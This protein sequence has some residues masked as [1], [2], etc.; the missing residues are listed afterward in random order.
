M[1]DW[2]GVYLDKCMQFASIKKLL[3]E[4]VF[5]CDY[6]FLPIVGDMMGQMKLRPTKVSYAIFIEE[7]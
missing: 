7:G 2:K 6:S 4:V 1:T 5:H 3:G